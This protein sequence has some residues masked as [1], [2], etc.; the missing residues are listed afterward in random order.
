MTMAN[1]ND[2]INNGPYPDIISILFCKA[3]LHF[4]CINEELRCKIAYIQCY[5]K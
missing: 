2:D 3:K 4:M 5:P 1:S